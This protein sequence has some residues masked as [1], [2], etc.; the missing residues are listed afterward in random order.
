MAHDDLAILDKFIGDEGLEEYTARWAAHPFKRI[1]LRGNCLG[2]RG[3]AILADYL[4]KTEDVEELSLEWNQIGSSGARLLARALE[5]NVSL[6]H[7]DL[8]NNNI[9]SDGAEEL[10][11][12]LEINKSLKSLDLRWNKL[13]DSGALCFKAAILNRIP[14]LQLKV[15]GNYLTGSTALSIENWLDGQYDEAG[16]ES[17]SDVGGVMNFARTAESQSQHDQMMKAEAVQLRKD[18]I[19]MQE[20]VQHLHKQLEASALQVNEVEQ[21][22]L[23]QAFRADTAEE[24]LK[25]TDARVAQYT[26]EIA[27]LT[28]AW[29]KDRQEAATELRHSLSL[30]DEELS[31]VM[32][33]RDTA[34]SAARREG[35][36][37]ERL[38]HA[39]DEQ[40]KA[41][42][43]ERK[44]VSEE[45]ASLQS[46]LTEMTLSDS[47][48]GGQVASLE[49][50]VKL[51][52]A[53]VGQ[54]EKDLKS[55]R[56]S[57]EAT[58][59]REMELREE[60]EERLKN[61]YE[62]QISTLSDQNTRKS[63]E[64][65]IVYKKTQAL[66]SELA[67]KVAEAEAEKD[68]AVTKAREDE[69]KR[70]EATL[71]D[72]KQ[73]IDMFL[74]GRSELQKRCDEYLKELSESKET[75][76]EAN[77][78]MAA[79]VDAAEKECERLRKTVAEMRVDLT[80]SKKNEGD[81][82]V[83]AEELS[84][85]KGKLADLNKDQAAQLEQATNECTTLKSKVREMK[86][87]ESQAQARLTMMF[88]NI[89][90]TVSSAV[91]REFDQ[92]QKSN[93]I[94]SVQKEE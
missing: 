88:H 54:L 40:S 91:S 72:Q 60:L 22:A 10:A 17:K 90:E 46:A 1:V 82:H 39:Q 2:E 5:R 81:A 69:A 83:R 56:E 67:S 86:L 15:S 4:S 57:S 63:K 9:K 3:A 44:G 33:E 43:M 23:K 51:S 68:K 30:K 47:H 71:A 26:E 20:Q 53:K 14:K 45:L 64:L 75:Q 12:A 27:S 58:L 87:A 36:K 55:M 77:M 61:D 80:A 59:A 93:G 28:Q 24:K 49:G 38:Q 74:S 29:E 11:K 65:E 6:V 52:E 13:E 41:M 79:Q 73:K 21:R 70:V 31:K 50:R 25:S 37:A 7:L 32:D 16:E 19:N 89:S 92:L 35:Q 84:I 66:Q 42:E 8:R 34:N 18:M 48:K 76:K 85:E 94:P 62:A 78:Q